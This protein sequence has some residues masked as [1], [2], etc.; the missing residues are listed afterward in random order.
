MLT[1][2]EYLDSVNRVIREEI[3]TEMQ[4]LQYFLKA[5]ARQN[6]DRFPFHFLVKNCRLEVIDALAENLQGNGWTVTRSKDFL[7]I[8]PATP[9]VV[10]PPPLPRTSGNK[11]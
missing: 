10:F 1:G 6:N 8:T 5:N 3:D 11:P 9:S 2:K 4:R 7:Y